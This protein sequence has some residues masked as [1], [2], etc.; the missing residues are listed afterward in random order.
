MIKPMHSNILV[1]RDEAATSTSG[2]I[3]L[4]TVSTEKKKTG[5]VLAVG[6]GRISDTGFVRPFYVK[7]GDRITFSH[8]G[9]EVSEDGVVYCIMPEDNVLA[10]IE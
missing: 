4:P 7:V 10:V 3:V 8:F 1:L 2:G 6:P 5:K 9:S